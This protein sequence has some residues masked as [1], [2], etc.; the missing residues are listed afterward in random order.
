MAAIKAFTCKYVHRELKW[1]K[2][3]LLEDLERW[4]YKDKPKE[5]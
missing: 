4:K 2:H 3:D 5:R 1:T